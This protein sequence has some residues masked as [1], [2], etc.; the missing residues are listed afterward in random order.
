[1]TA[2]I[3]VVYAVAGFAIYWPATQGYG[4]A[5]LIVALGCF[6]AC[7]AATGAGILIG[8]RQP[9]ACA[10]LIR[11]SAGAVLVVVSGA[12]AA[13]IVIAVVVITARGSNPPPRT[14]EVAAVMTAALAGFAGVVTDAALA[15]TPARLSKALIQKR[16]GRALQQMPAQ[17]PQLDAYFATQRESFGSVAFGPIDGWGV[18][19]TRRRLQLI[20]SA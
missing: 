11:A 15:I 6:V 14:E 17:Q 18:R 9:T 5:T 3:G 4:W 13:I 19:S 16:Y 10:C 2:L 20:A 7:V 12:L 8:T 1:M